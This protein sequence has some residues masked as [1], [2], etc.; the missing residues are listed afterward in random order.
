MKLPNK[1]RKDN[2][3][4][5]SRNQVHGRLQ[6]HNIFSYVLLTKCFYN[7]LQKGSQS[8]EEAVHTN[9]S[10]PIFI[11]FLIHWTEMLWGIVFQ[12]DL[13]LVAVHRGDTCDYLPKISISVWSTLLLRWLGVS[14]MPFLRPAYSS[15]NFN[16]Y[17]MKYRPIY[18]HWTQFLIIKNSR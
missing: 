6:C 7:I 14:R 1:K 8:K 18:Y 17:S 10:K 3:L 16:Q 2:S 15:S 11:P 4:N 9:P 13:F 12:L 5:F